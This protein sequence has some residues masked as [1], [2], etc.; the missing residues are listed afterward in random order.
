MNSGGGPF[1]PGTNTTPEGPKPEDMPEAF[2]ASFSDKAI[3]MAFIRKVYLI[4][5]TQLLVTLGIVSLFT[6]Q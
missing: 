2:G 5:M 1:Q 3:R 6:F 4:L